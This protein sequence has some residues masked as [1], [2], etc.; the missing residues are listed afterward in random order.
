MMKE[1]MKTYTYNTTEMNFNYGTE[2]FHNTGEVTV[3]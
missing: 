2:E 1:D 3:F